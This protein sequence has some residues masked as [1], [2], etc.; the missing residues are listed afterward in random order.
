MSCSSASFFSP[1]GGQVLFYNSCGYYSLFCLQSI[2]VLHVSEICGRCSEFVNFLYNV[3]VYTD[4]LIV[5]GEVTYICMI[6]IL[7]FL[8]LSS[9]TLTLSSYIE[10]DMAAIG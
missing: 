5:K 8:L 1:M 3:C 6:L 9:C 7:C 2:C 4:Q 10:P